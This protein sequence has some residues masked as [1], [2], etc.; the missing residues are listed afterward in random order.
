MEKK[1]LQRVIGISVV[2]A[3]VI[4]LIPFLFGKREM[5]QQETT[6]QV[7]TEQQ[8][9]TTDA[10]QTTAA[11]TDSNPPTTIQDNRNI[12]NPADSTN[13][14]A[15]T[16]ATTNAD[17]N[18]ITPITTPP[19]ASNDA[20]TAPTTPATMNPTEMNNSAA[21]PSQDATGQQTSAINQ[22]ANPVN[23]ANANATTTTPATA[24]VADEIATPAENTIQAA[25]AVS[26]DATND[27][28]PQATAEKTAVKAPIKHAKTASHK[29]K[30]YAAR[31]T[32][33]FSGQQVA[34]L[35]KSAW[36]VQM[37]SFKDKANAHRMA[38][39]LKTSGFKVFT[40]VVTSPAGNVRTRVYIGPE[41]K[42]A[43]AQQLT[44]KIQRETK[45]QGFVLPYKSIAL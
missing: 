24:P 28:H 29:H 33:H 41:F 31:K 38:E 42:Q 17:D 27:V 15:Q 4:V 26:T 3:F 25:P 8:T 11:N 13:P 6:A 2:V 32:N 7:S 23:P 16:T 5:P 18:G 19:V 37:G 12:N 9:T 20:N 40:K 30:S 21:A 35:N 22:P 43:S 39:Q 45:L 1:K 44:T 34:N 14:N 10:N 36:V